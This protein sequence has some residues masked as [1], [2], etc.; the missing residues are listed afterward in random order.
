MSKANLIKLFIEWTDQDF[1]VRTES[2]WAEGLSA[3][4]FRIDNVPFFVYGLSCNDVVVADIKEENFFL[5]K[6]IERGGHSTLRVFFRESHQKEQEVLIE[7]LNQLGA[8]IERAY[9]KLIA[10]DIPSN[11]DIDP[12]IELL[13]N[14]ESLGAWEYEVGYVHT[15]K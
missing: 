7:K 10:I 14:G 3:N 8:T 6:V 12:I 9:E 1:G 2:V 15:K 4:T 5:N 13:K 11:V